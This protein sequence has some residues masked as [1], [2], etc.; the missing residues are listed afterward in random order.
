VAA[1]PGTVWIGN[2]SFDRVGLPTDLA[3]RSL[4]HHLADGTVAE[5]CLHAHGGA[6][7]GSRWM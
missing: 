3:V 2:R 5:L 6:L 4:A 7:Q 1:D